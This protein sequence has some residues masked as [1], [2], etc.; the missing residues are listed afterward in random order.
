[1]S[2]VLFSA[3]LFLLTLLH[4][5]TVNVYINVAQVEHVEQIPI[6]QRFKDMPNV[7]HT[8]HNVE[9]RTNLVGKQKKPPAKA[10]TD[11]Y[12]IINP[13]VKSIISRESKLTNPHFASK[14]PKVAMDCAEFSAE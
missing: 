2:V 5:I 12:I 6:Q 10:T 8:W 7:E 14:L 9:Q 11:I 1:M 3:A 13:K 4:T